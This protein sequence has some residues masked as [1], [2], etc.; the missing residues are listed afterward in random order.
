MV[1]AAGWF[2][3]RQRGGFGGFLSWRRRGFGCEIGAQ[4]GFGGGGGEVRLGFGGGG[5]EVR[6]AN[7]RGAVADRGG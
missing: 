3:R 7:A 2:H 1:S 6:E 5:G 4:L